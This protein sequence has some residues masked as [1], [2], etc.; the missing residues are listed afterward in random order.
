[1]M[2]ETTQKSEENKSQAL[3]F[4]KTQKY[5]V[6]RCLASTPN[7]KATRWKEGTRRRNMEWFLIPMIHHL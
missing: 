3:K 5:A 4:K 1:M 7:F 2:E 6:P